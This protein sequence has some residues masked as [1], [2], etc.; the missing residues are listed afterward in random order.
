MLAAMPKNVVPLPVKSPQ[1]ENGFTRIANELL[2]AMIAARLSARQWSVVMAVVR[3]TYGFNKKEDDIGLG[4]LASMTGIDKAHLSRAVRELADLNIITRS[5]GTHGHKLG[6]NKNFDEWGLL[7]EQ[8]VAESA[9]SCQNSN[10]PV[11]ERAT[12]PVAESA[13][14]KDNSSKDNY[15]KTKDIPSPPAPEE[16][17]ARVTKPKSKVAMTA[18]L[19]DRFDRFYGAYPRKTG[20][21][22]AGAVFARLQPDE[23]QLTEMLAALER[24]KV[25]GKHADRQY[26]KHPA[27]WLNKGCWEDEIQTE[28]TPQQ[29]AVIDAYNDALGAALGFMD[30]SVFSEQRAGRL[31]DFMGL[32]DKAEFWLRYFPY[33]RDSC[34][35]PPGVGLDYLIGREGF[36]KVKG[37]Q[38]ERKA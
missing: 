10:P 11:A 28:Y 7:K 8:P 33:V 25:A 2:D 1:L 31:D 23:T 37:G 15:Q 12:P 13:T 38:H 26:I 34:E 16:S 4:Q 21:K 29:R 30:A 36:T 9:A 35:L 20:R 3:K 14:T 18:E 32:S 27:T 6:I 17:K 22:E 19:Q 5:A 24:E